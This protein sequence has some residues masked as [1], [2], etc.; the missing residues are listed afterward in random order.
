MSSAGSDEAFLR[1]FHRAHAG[2]TARVLARGG[3]YA[4]LAACVP[5]GARVLDLGCADG[6][7]VA[8][9]RA[10]G[11]DAI[12]LDLEPGGAQPVVQGRASA[13]PFLDATFDAV[14]SH[15]GIDVMSPLDAIVAECA[16]VMRPGGLLAAIVGGGPTADGDDAF[17]R[18]CALAPAIDVALGD[19]RTRDPERWLPGATVERV[20]LDLSGTFDEVW[21]VLGSGY[22]LFDR[23]AIAVRDQLRAACA[24][25]GDRV[26]CTMV[27]WLVRR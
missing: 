6:E 7:L 5:I 20:A 8:M 19:P 13:L 14:V 1:R 17:H 10:R 27:V 9:L 22:E 21:S 15:L 26:P 16:R 12:G 23:D 2:I 18:Y 25:F 11:C 3:S 24:E 4:R